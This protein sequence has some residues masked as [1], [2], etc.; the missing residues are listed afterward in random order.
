MARTTTVIITCDRCKTSIVLDFQN[1]VRINS[2]QLAHIINSVE[3][4]KD[5][6]VNMDF[7]GT[8]CMNSAL[9]ELITAQRK[10]LI[11]ELETAQ[12]EATETIV[13]TPTELPDDPE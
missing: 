2:I 4:P 5:L 13:D 9:E 1:P 7:C 8:F 11:K 3:Y 6:A 10:A 12:E